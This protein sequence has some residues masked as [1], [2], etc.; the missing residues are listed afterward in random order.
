MLD[1]NLSC[2]PKTRILAGCRRSWLPFFSEEFRTKLYFRSPQSVKRLWDRLGNSAF[3][4]KIFSKISENDVRFSIRFFWFH[5]PSSELVQQWYTHAIR[6]SFDRSGLVHEL[7]H[8]S[9]ALQF[10]PELKNAPVPVESDYIDFSY[11]LFLRRE[12]TERERKDWLQKLRDTNWSFEAFVSSFE[13]SHEYR[14]RLKVEA[15]PYLVEL[16]QFNLYVRLGDYFTSAPIAL[17]KDYEPFISHLIDKIVQ[18]DDYVVDVGANVGY[19]ALHMAV[20]VGNR[21]KIFAFEP[22]PGNCELIELSVEA[23]QFTNLQLFPYAAGDA[24]GEI[25]LLV[26][27]NH[28]NARLNSNP[29]FASPRAERY[30]VRIVKIDD[31]LGHIP[32]L[33]F[34]KIDAEGAEPMVVS[35]MSDLITRHRPILLFEFFP[36]FISMTSQIDPQRFLGQITDFGYRLHVVGETRR[37]T[38]ASTP[39]QI[40]LKQ[41]DS[42][43]THVDILAIP[44]E[45]KGSPFV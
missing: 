3:A 2:T 15:Q 6:F 34:V 20:L 44:V 28:T 30:P 21:G 13:D 16:D 40:M 27:G 11:R 26:E 23:N 24:A 19:H 7:Q 12:P 1:I 18:P 37:L 8:S 31:C 22:H 14:Q 4:K 5:E 41:K 38:E 32:R 43:I 25:E 29:E 17:R 9:Q 42:G 36:D 45:L 35:G 33:H 10:E 39:S